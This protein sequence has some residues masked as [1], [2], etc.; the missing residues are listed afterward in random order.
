MTLELVEDLVHFECGED[1]LDED[2]AFHA[3]R[4]EPEDLLRHVENVVPE[5]CLQ[6]VL[7]LRKVV[8]WSRALLSKILVVVVEVEPKVEE[9]CRNRLALHQYMFLG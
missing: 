2:C 5:T 9:G 7:Q 3:V 4:R 1:V 8:V 6:M